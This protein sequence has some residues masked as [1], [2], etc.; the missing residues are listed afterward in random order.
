M[1]RGRPGDEDK[2]VPCMSVNVKCRVVLELCDMSFLLLITSTIVRNLL[3]F[4]LIV[5][6]TFKSSVNWYKINIKNEYTNKNLL[7]NK[8]LIIDSVHITVTVIKAVET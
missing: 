8:M 2:T 7:F 6:S 4:E 5:A 3:R 1:A